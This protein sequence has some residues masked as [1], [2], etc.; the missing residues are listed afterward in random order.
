[1]DI[2]YNGCSVIR[3]RNNRWL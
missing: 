2:V 1:M 3:L